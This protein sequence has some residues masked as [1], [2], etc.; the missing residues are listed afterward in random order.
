[1]SKHSIGWTVVAVAAVF[2]VGISLSGLTQHA[3]ADQVLPGGHAAKIRSYFTT[4][5]GGQ[6]PTVFIPSVEG[7]HGTIFTDFQV[8]A[9]GNTA[10]RVRLEYNDGTGWKPALWWKQDP[11][12]APATLSS[13]IPIPAGAAVRVAADNGTAYVTVSG[14]IW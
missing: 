7:D 5:P 3:S 10:G 6:T 12:A 4:I 14:Y 9:D 2:A 1:M 13:G 11:G 8:A